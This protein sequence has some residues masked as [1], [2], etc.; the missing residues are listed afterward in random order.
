METGLQEGLFALLRQKGAKLVGAADLTGLVDDCLTTGVAVAIPVPIH[1]VED[2]RTVPTLEYYEMYHTLNRELDEM[3]AA[4]AKFLRENGYRAKANTK[5]GM[6][7]SEDLCTPL[8]YKTVATRAGLG[9][10]GKSCLLVTEE[11]GS[12]VRLSSLVTDAPL[13]TATP[14]NK[15]RCGKCRVCVD[16]CPGKAILGTLWEAGMP[17]EEILQS[18]VCKATQI[19][20]MQ[21]ILGFYEGERVCGRCFAVCAYTQRYIKREG[22]A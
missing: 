14:I 11:Y 3:V 8:P 1:I 12:A 2:V 22:K 5:K 18:Q 7:V 13:T 6:Q 10:I 19:E 21:Q 17:R 9:W 15:S 4:G 16:V 20:R